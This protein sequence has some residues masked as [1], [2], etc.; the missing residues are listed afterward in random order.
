MHVLPPCS[1]NTSH[2]CIITH[3]C[4]YDCFYYITLLLVFAR[5]YWQFFTFFYF[6]FLY[7][8]VIIFIINSQT[9]SIR[10]V[11]QKEICK[12]G[13]AGRLTDLFFWI[14]YGY[15]IIGRTFLK[16]FVS[17]SATAILIRSGMMNG[18]THQP[19]TVTRPTGPALRVYMI[20]NQTV[21]NA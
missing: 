19:S 3:I 8:I 5:F 11:T 20:I 6:L 15:C 21:P 17:P 1:I 10:G 18:K 4:N 14:S 9:T 7:H 2:V 12:S 13:R 16:L